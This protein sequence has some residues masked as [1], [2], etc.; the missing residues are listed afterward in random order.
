MQHQAVLP[1]GLSPHPEV[2]VKE[3]IVRQQAIAAGCCNHALPKGCP[4]AAVL[5]AGQVG[6][7]VQH[8]PH[9][10]AAP[11]QRE[12]ITD[13]QAHKSYLLDVWML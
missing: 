10:P 12:A 9:I 4:A 1:G 13:L 7:P 2:Q 11:I 5:L 6:R 8:L 3:W